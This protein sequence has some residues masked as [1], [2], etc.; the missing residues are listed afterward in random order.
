MIC[1]D[2]GTKELWQANVQKE[3][4]AFNLNFV[5]GNPEF[6]LINPSLGGWE[7]VGETTARKWLEEPH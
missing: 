5:I 4:T 7:V 1:H 2:G 3:L 6:D